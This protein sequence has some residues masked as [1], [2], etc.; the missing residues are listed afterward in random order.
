MKKFFVKILT[1]DI[2]KDNIIYEY[3]INAHCDDEA[4]ENAYDLAKING[5]AL[6]EIKQVL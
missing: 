2:F 1:N 5:G 6:V 4:Y 3:M